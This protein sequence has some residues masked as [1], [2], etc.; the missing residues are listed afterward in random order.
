MRDEFI[1]I[2]ANLCT[3]TTVSQYEK[4][5]AQMDDMA[6]IYPLKKWI[7]WWH[8]R[9]SHIFLPFCG[10]GIPMVNLSKQG[11]KVIKP[12]H[13]LQLVHTAKYDTAVMLFQSK[14]L[15]LYSMNM[16]SVNSRG[17][18]QAE[19]ATRE[20]HD[21][22][23]KILVATDFNNILDNEEDVEAEVMEVIDPHSYVPKH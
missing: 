14:W 5:K 21:R 16:V 13:T 9:H 12:S 7:K 22:D 10:S 15:D 19:E 20:D 4:L 1:Q 18:N 3:V 8:A 23:G 6:R 2:C 11:N 17:A